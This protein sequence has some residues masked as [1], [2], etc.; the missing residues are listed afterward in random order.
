MRVS[1]FSVN[2]ADDSESVEAL[3]VE[4]A[5]F[6]PDDPEDAATVEAELVANG[7]TY[8]GGG[9]APLFHFVI[10]TEQSSP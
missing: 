8:Y 1:L 5:S 4:L 2:H 6:F 7:S 3:D 10:F 9:A